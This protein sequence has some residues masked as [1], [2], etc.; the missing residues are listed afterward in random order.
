MMIPRTR[1][2]APIMVRCIRFSL[3]PKPKLN[4][5][6]QRYASNAESISCEAET[7]GHAVHNTAMSTVNPIKQSAKANA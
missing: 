3:M 1:A 7:L 4:S 2:A 5:S 6:V